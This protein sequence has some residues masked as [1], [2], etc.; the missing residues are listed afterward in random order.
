[1]NSH[2]KNDPANRANH[3]CN[4]P[5]NHAN[6]ICALKLA[7]RLDRVSAATENPRFYCLFCGARVAEMTSVCHPELIS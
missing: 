7:G 5:E 4:D 6:H 3:I 2:I 1:M